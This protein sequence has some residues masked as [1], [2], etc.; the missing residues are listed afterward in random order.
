MAI[1]HLSIGQVQLGHQLL[2]QGL[3]PRLGAA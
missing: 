1:Q 3:Q 2:L